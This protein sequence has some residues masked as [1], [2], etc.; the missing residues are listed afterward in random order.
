[1]LFL[2]SFV[3]ALMLLSLLLPSAV[4]A[5]RTE[6]YGADKEHAKN[7]FYFADRDNWDEALAHAKRAQNELLYD[8]ILWKA[9]SDWS[10]DFAFDDFRHFLTRNPG[11][12][13][14]NRLLLRAED[15]LFANPDVVPDAELLRWFHLYPPTTGKGQVV[16]AHALQRTGKGSKEQ[17]T[18]LL[19]DAWINGDFAPDRVKDLYRLHR[20]ILR[21]ED[22]IARADRLVWDGQTSAA[23]DMFFALPKGQQK[24][25]EAR[26]RLQLNKPGVTN[27]IAEVPANLKDDPGLLYERMKWR[28][29][30]RL[31]DGVA[32]IL[33]QA[34]VTVPYPEKWWSARHYAAREALQS[35]LHSMTLKL[36]ENH[37]QTGGVGQAEA[38]WLQGWVKL[39]FANDAQ[40]A[41]KAFREME[42]AVGTPVSL[43]RASYWAGRAAEALGRKEDAKVHYGRGAAFNTTFYGQLAAHK[44]HKNPP[45]ELPR[46]ARLGSQAINQFEKDPRV[47]AVYLLA[48]MGRSN[49][50]Y[51]FI[52]R[53]MD[54]AKRHSEA[55]MTAELGRHIRQWH[56]GVLASKEALRNHLVLPSTSYMYYQ[57]PF[58]PPVEPAYMWA[59]TRQESVFNH[60]A[61]SRSGARGLMQLMP[62]TAREVAQKMGLYYSPAKLNDAAY[63]LQ[64]GSY[65]L[66]TLVDQFSGSYV[67]ATAGYNAGP[68]RSRQ[69]MNERGHPGKNVEE[70]V[71]WIEMIP[72]SETRNYVQRVLENLQVYRAVLE[73]KGA[74][75]QLEKDLTR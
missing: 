54:D 15:R 10:S 49:E 40:G 66:A 64:L 71:N 14:E 48:E 46:I 59:I 45:M 21:Q 23:A 8:Y 56:F 29:R 26:I 32:E 28:E 42:E 65:Y 4:L 39:T 17:I 9:L 69:W 18:T 41:L 7:A 20:D 72:Y 52:S 36:L 24:L 1:M 60:E 44:L 34:P 63:N 67:L 11:W 51:T 25:M 50:A 73:P 33:L 6:L 70:V 55:L 43:S 74:T 30:K 62:G 31:Y 61:Q 5:A 75:I 53:L 16:Y 38:L 19:R 68:G 47:R 12:P 27:A 2:R 57:V 37:G 35:G 58:K 22:H 3:T 13:R